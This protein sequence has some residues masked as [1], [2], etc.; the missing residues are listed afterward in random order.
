MLFVQ[1]VDLRPP[2][3]WHSSISGAAMISYPRM[4]RMYSSPEKLL[5]PVFR[6]LSGVVIM[7]EA[8]LLLKV[9]LLT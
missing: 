7:I 3:I 4:E 6:S 2:P 5:T 1:S 8:A 9:K